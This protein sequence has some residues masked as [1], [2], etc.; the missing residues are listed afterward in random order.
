MSEEF[1]AVERCWKKKRDNDVAIEDVCVLVN[2]LFPKLLKTTFPS[3]S[4]KQPISM[5][6]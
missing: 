1:E 6:L 5:L 2:S 4:Y 3:R